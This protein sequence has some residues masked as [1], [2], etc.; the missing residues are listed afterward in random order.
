M[1]KWEVGDILIESGT[2]E[3]FIVKEIRS[4]EYA[5]ESEHTCCVPEGEI[6][7]LLRYFSDGGLAFHEYDSE[8]VVIRSK[9]FNIL[10]G[11]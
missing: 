5:R 6:A 8:D 11:D 7:Y 10:Y 4:Y 1:D 3:K 2:L 9:L